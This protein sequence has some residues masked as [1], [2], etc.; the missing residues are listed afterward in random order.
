[1]ALQTAVYVKNLSF[2]PTASHDAIVRI[3]EL[4]IPQRTIVSIL[5][6]SGCG[7]T[8]FLSLVGGLYRP[9]QEAAIELF[10]RHVH[11]AVLGGEVSL[12]FQAPVLMSWRTAYENVRLAVDLKGR[13]VDDATIVAALASVELA[14]HAAKFPGELSHGARLTNL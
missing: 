7:K 6:R 8:T 2:A 10:G 9:N 5:G 14:T 4:E 1:M 13:Y 12:S 11:D 3:D